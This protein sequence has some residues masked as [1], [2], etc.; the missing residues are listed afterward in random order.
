MVNGQSQVQGFNTEQALVYCRLAADQL[1]ATKMDRCEDVQP[2]LTHREDLRRLH[3][4]HRP[5]QTR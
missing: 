2:N 4:Q 3:E 5:R 1:G